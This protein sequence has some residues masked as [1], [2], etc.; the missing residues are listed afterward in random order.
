MAKIAGIDLGTTFS[1]ISHLNDMGH[2]EVIPNM[3]GERIM[4]SAVHFSEGGNVLV[5]EEAVKSRYEEPTRSVRWIKAHMGDADHRTSIDGEE[6]TP[7][8]LSALILKKLH[9][10]SIP[11][12]GKVTDVVISIPANFGEVAR[13]AT[14][15]AGKIAGLNVVGLVNEP[16]AAAF[17]YAITIKQ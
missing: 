12:I 14:M 13:K 5:G 1:A 7:A 17:Y 4:H 15:D 6:H 9:Q 3:D 8:E 11:Q 2:P 16:T 10:D